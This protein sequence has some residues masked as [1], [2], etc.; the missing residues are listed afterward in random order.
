MKIQTVLVS[1]VTVFSAQ[2]IQLNLSQ[3]DELENR[4]LP[5][6]KK[7]HFQNEA[8]CSAFLVKMS[9]ICMSMKNYFHIKD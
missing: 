8:K 6:A 9:F 7:P 3:I 5:S 1:K 4:S 2:K